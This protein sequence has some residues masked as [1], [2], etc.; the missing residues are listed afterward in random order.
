YTDPQYLQ[1]LQNYKL[2]K[3]SDVYS[4]GVL[5]KLSSGAIP[6]RSKLP[7]D[8]NLLSEI[9]HGRRES[10]VFGTPI[11]YIKIY[12]ECWQHDSYKRPTIQYGYETLKSINHNDIINENIATKCG[13]DL[14]HKKYVGCINVLYRLV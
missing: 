8:F 4:I 5:W 14:K 6:F 2:N 10:A 3:S 12:T 1:N 9:I 7:Y 13:I 11:L